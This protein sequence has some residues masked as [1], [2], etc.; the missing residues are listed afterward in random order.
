M[1]SGRLWICDVVSGADGLLILWA[2]SGIL[3]YWAHGRSGND[4]ELRCRLSARRKVLRGNHFTL[5]EVQSESPFVS[6]H[7]RLA[8]WLER[9]DS[10]DDSLD[11]ISLWL[12]RDGV[13]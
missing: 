8:E 5:Q 11:E 2:V 10:S 7:R 9:H 12:A 6:S 4:P 1:R 13:C 3:G